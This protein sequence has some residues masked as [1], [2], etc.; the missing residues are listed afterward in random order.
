MPRWASFTLTLVAVLV[1]AVKTTTYIQRKIQL[2]T[3]LKYSDKE[4]IHYTGSTTEEDARALGDALKGVGFFKGER[5]IDV[6]LNKKDGATTASFVVQDGKWDDEEVVAG[7]K[8]IG[9]TIA[10]AVP[11][12]PFTV[13][14]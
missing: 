9:E 10:V 11:G 12:Q 13:R 8:S 1:L 4:S 5:E 3:K 7:F 14:L 6:L 2:G